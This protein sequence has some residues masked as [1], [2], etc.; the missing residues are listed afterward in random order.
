MK[1]CITCSTEKLLTEFQLRTDTGKYR[2]Q[3]KRC[4]QDKVNL[5]R[6]SNEAYKQRYNDYRKNRRDTDP[7][8]LIKGRLRARIRKLTKAKNIEKYFKT[9]E[10]IGCDIK[11]FKTY[12]EKK[13]KGDMSWEKR[14]F[15]FDHII[16][17]SSF[18]LNDVE[19]QKICFHYTNI[20]PLTWLENAQKS[21]KLNYTFK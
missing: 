17:C 18:D 7:E 19:Q 16:P 1:K 13:F 3:C 20:Q 11:T 2:N 10:L 6:R 5:Y 12:I 14:N 9:M 21:N 8:Y 15:V 4:R